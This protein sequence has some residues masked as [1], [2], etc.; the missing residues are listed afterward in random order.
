MLRYLGLNNVGPAPKIELK[1]GERM[2]L[3]TGNNGLGM[4]F[5]LDAAWWALTR[6]WPREVNGRLTSGYR[7]L[8]RVVKQQEAAD[9][10]AP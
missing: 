2:T 1:P 8:P 6:T 7:A 3:L 9:A 5:L 10:S 4:S